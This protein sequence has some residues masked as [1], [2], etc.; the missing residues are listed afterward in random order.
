MLMP[1]MFW[2]VVRCCDILRTEFTAFTRNVYAIV[3]FGVGQ[4]I[5]FA[6]HVA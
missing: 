4:L 6:S 3:R 2:H 5:Y 1:V